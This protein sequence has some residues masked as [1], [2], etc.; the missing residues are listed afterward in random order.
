MPTPDVKRPQRNGAFSIRCGPVYGTVETGT[1]T[2]GPLE[3]AGL[4]A[5]MYPEQHSAEL[6]HCGGFVH[7]KHRPVFGSHLNPGQQ[8]LEVEHTSGFAQHV[9]FTGIVPAGHSHLQVV[10]LNT[11]PCG[12]ETQMPELGHMY[13]PGAQAH[14]AVVGSQNLLQHSSFSRQPCP[15]WK[16]RPGAPAAEPT[17]TS[18][19]TPPIVATPKILSAFRLDV[20]SESVF[21]SWSNS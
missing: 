5:Q 13:V 11:W 8:S 20:V 7:G 9:P 14:F 10:E 21:A 2:P 19:A 15:P 6:L 1:Q 12:Q 3:V 16:Q 17:P 18:E 4:S